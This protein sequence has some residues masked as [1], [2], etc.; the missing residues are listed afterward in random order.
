MNHKEYTVRVY[1]DRTEWLNSFGDFHRV[2]GPAI[3]Y[4]DGGKF[5]YI[6]G[7][8]SRLDGPALEYADGEKRWY[9]NDQLH[10]TDGPAIEFTDDRELYYL[11]GKY[12]SALEHQRALAEPAPCAEHTLSPTKE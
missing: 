11:K 4:V 5:W 9:M 7:E 12:L 1:A 8:F 2:D 10:R 6:N 3:E